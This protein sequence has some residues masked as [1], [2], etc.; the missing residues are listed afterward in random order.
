MEP[1]KQ[2]EPIKKTKPKTIKETSKCL[3]CGDECNFHSQLC[4]Y[5]IRRI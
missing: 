4:S 1:V 3:K 2:T 5:C